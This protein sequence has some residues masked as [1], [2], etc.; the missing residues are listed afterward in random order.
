MF[1]GAGK[2]VV[3]INAK[4]GMP[5]SSW[6]GDLPPALNGTPTPLSM[7]TYQVSRVTLAKIATGRF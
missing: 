6:S 4:T 7:T 5:I 3:V 1:G 2:N